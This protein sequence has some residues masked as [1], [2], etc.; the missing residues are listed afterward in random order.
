[1]ASAAIKNS[2]CG[3]WLSRYGIK[4]ARNDLRRSPEE[5]ICQVLPPGLCLDQ[6]FP[7]WQ[8]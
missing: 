5:M 3:T 2:H 7:V 4:Q 1:M 6:L 8:S